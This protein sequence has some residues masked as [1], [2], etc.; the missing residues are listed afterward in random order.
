LH[1]NAS[2]NKKAMK[3]VPFLSLLLLLLTFFSA[4]AQS[5]DAVKIYTNQKYRGDHLNVYEE[6]S[7]YDGDDPW[8]DNI[9]SI[10]IP[11][12]W[13]VWVYSDGYFRGDRWILTSNWNGRNNRRWCD[14]ISSL[15][16]V[17]KN[18]SDHW[19]DYGGFNHQIGYRI[20]VTIFEDANFE[21]SSR[22][23]QWEWT[24]T[25]TDRFWN[26]RISSIY[27]PEGFRVILYEHTYFRGRRMVIEQSWSAP[28]GKNWW[29][30]QVSS[31]RVERI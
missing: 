7:A 29:N 9:E 22:R 13:E 19:D 31:I 16:I 5:N 18:R 15:R 23:I 25:N 6:W 21:G 12:G 2:L 10:R 1:F 11:N 24:A 27:V 3:A 4:A 20:P 26:D 30:D 28:R 17:R 14:R 8:N